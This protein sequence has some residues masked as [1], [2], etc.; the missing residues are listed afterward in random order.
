MTTAHSY[1]I[2]LS[3]AERKEIA[4]I[5]STPGINE[6]LMRRARVLM[7]LDDGLSAPDIVRYLQISRSTVYSI[8]QR[9]HATNLRG[10]LYDGRRS[11]TP[12]RIPPAA[13]SWIESVM[14][15]PPRM[16]GVDADRWTITALQTYV[17]ENGPQNG[18]PEV[19]QISRSYL[20]R[21]LSEHRLPQ[22][23]EAEAK[24]L[25]NQ[26]AKEARIVLW[27]DVELAIIHEDGWWRPLFRKVVA[28]A[29]SPT[30]F[31]VL[32]NSQTLPLPEGA[33]A[34]SFITGFEFESGVIHGV[35][36]NSRNEEQMIAF[37]KH[38]DAET[39]RGVMI[40]LMNKSVPFR[41][42]PG[43]Y[44]FLF[45]RMGRFSI[46]QNR[47]FGSLLRTTMNAVS[48]LLWRL[49]IDDLRA[50]TRE[51]L[52]EKLFVAVESFRI[53]DRIGKAA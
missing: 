43:V 24:T 52:V 18:Y 44:K 5:L 50:R 38:L 47:Q 45:A 20:W 53:E 8:S 49:H 34:V 2:K 33:E 14:K 21:I 12:K 25:M 1:S 41:L 9:F 16:V 40:E 3:D 48:Q 46:V 32:P 22:S 15:E 4:D 29:A 19:S 30:G 10:A 42:S 6:K 37:L 31:A 35:I 39:P 13:F 26:N 17:R 27:R 11:G 36:G 7:L 51:E 23:E 28:N